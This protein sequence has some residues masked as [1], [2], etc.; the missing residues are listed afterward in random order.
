M[1]LPDRLPSYDELPEFEGLGERHA[2]DVF[3][4]DDNL[5]TVNLLTPERVV[6]AAKL[7]RRGAVINVSL[8]MDQPAPG[9]FPDRPAYAH[10]REMTRTGSDDSVDG[11]QMQ[12]SSQWDGLRHIRFRDRGFYQG[13]QEDE[14]TGTSGRLGIDHWARHGIFGR[15]VLIDMPR[16][17]L[18]GPYDAFSRITL[19]GPMIERIAAREGIEVREGDIMLVRTGWLERYRS[20]DAAGREALVGTIL[21]AEFPNAHQCAGLDQSQET[22]AW[23]WNRHLVTIAADNPALE[24]LPVLN[25][26]FQHRR[27][28]PMFGMPIGEFWDFEELA[29]DCARDG[30]YECFFAASPLYLP[31]SAGSPANAHV[32]K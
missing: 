20:L 22:A 1:A 12:G 6:A 9:L 29:E 16:Y 3:G 18:D 14:V 30:V 21:P 2:W 23:V 27:L 26:E 7:I 28:I 8:P 17:A 24:A 15:A 13:V 32:I 4:P 31:G 19:D 25:R 10:H 5:G 11:F